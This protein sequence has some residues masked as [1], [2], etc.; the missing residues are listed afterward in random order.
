[1]WNLWSRIVPAKKRKRV[2]FEIGMAYDVMGQT[3][4]VSEV[5][6]E[7]GE[8]SVNLVSEETWQRMR[9]GKS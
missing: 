6:K 7:P 3:M 4:V 5:I 8:F 2:S 9:R 1:M